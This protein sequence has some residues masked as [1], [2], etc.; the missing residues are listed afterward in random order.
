MVTC[1]IPPAAL[2]TS[3]NFVIKPFTIGEGTIAATPAVTT[4]PVNHLATTRAA[5]RALDFTLAARELGAL[6]S[7]QR[8]EPA[9]LRLEWLI[10]GAQRNWDECLRIGR[11]LTELAP[12]MSSSWIALAKSLHRLGRWNEAE[13]VLQFLE[14]HFPAEPLAQSLRERLRDENSVSHSMGV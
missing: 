10:N 8:S 13:P 7:A 14:Q 9:A 2:A 4:P 6:D 1:S 11:T 5:I 3:T 12:T